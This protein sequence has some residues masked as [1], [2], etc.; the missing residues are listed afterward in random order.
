MLPNDK[1]RRITTYHRSPPRLQDDDIMTVGTSY[2]SSAVRAE[3]NSH[4]RSLSAPENLRSRVPTY[5]T[6]HSRR[7]RSENYNSDTSVHHPAARCTSLLSDLDSRYSGSSQRQVYSKGIIQSRGRNRSH[8]SS[9]LESN[10]PLSQ[11]SF[12][13]QNLVSNLRTALHDPA[14]ST[15][16]LNSS[17]QLASSTLLSLGEQLQ[18]IPFEYGFEPSQSMNSIS[19]NTTTTDT[20]ASSEI[21]YVEC[22]QK[23]RQLG[24]TKQTSILL[25]SE[26]NRVVASENASHPYLS[27]KLGNH[28]WMGLTPQA[29][30][31]T[32]IELKIHGKLKLQGTKTLCGKNNLSRYASFM[33]KQGTALFQRDIKKISNWGIGS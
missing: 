9:S 28:Q 30:K 32:T 33:R 2:E 5:F 19:A 18:S 14:S 13:S 29:T 27:T 12:T 11:T 4:S 8:S 7:N 1:M 22:P 3:L 26:N 31:A 21:F 10:Q 16:N 23:Q 6:A 24:V 20:N 17:D 25:T 15:N